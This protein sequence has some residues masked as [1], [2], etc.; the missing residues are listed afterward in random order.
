MP[1]ATSV[2]V[3]MPTTRAVVVDDDGLAVRAAEQVLGGLGEQR[4]RARRVSTS[5]SIRSPTAC[6]SETRRAAE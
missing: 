6:A 2:R 4:V 1:R 3:R 5:V